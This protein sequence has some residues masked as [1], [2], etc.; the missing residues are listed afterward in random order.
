MKKL[1]LF[2]FTVALA[3]VGC[4]QKTSEKEIP[5]SAK[6]AFEKNYPMAKEVKWEKEDEM[7]EVNF[8]FNGKDY[9]VLYDANGL[10]VETEIEMN[11][12]QL[13]EKAQAY[14]KTNYAGKKVKEAA[15]ITK[16]D[17]TLTYEA[18]V[19]GIDVLFDASGTFIKEAK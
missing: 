13:P 17:G 1:I 4:A 18:E 7:F 16:A 5:V 9:S 3:T 8:D 19:N 11:Q 14:L 12:H 6:T 15:V 2:G 10:C